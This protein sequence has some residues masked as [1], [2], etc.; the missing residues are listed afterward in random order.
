M[1]DDPEL[2][3]YFALNETLAAFDQ[4]LL[5]IKGWGVSLGL[6]AL[7]FGFQY[8][9]YGLFLVAATSGVAFW[10]LEAA[11]K[12]HQMRH[13]PRIREIEVNRCLREPEAQRPF[14]SPRISWS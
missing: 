9:S 7:G 2:T 14:S 3:E 8:R 10:L 5:T 1:A 12:R 6:A 11:T 4:R 13:Y